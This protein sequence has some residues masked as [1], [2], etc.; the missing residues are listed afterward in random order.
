VSVGLDKAALELL[1][2]NPIA[3]IVFPAV[4]LEPKAT[5]TLPV[6]PPVSCPEGRWETLIAIPK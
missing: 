3:I 4:L 6:N 2:I 1:D 5:A